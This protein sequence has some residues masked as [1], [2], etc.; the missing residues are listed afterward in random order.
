MATLLISINKQIIVLLN[1][2]GFLFYFWIVQSIRILK[3]EDV[4][5]RDTY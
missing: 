4:K 1:I 5:D 2:E 3:D